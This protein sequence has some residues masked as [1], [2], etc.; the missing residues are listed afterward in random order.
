[1]NELDRVRQLLPWYA[2]GVLVDEECA[3][4]DQWLKANVTKYP[5]IA[6]ELAWLR[7]TAVQL[8]ALARAARQPVD[9]GL[10]TLMQR[11]AFERPREPGNLLDDAI[12]DPAQPAVIQ[13]SKLTGTPHRNSQ[14]GDQPATGM[15]IMAWF[16]G[17]TG[18]GSPALAMGLVA[19]VIAQTGVIG[20]LL[21]HAP[22]NQVSL[23]GATDTVAASIDQVFLKVAFNPG[24]TESAL[25]HVLGS[26]NAQIVAGPS[27]LGLYTVAVS[28]AQVDSAIAQLRRNA[29]VVESVQR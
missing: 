21:M 12:Q 8:Q 2:Q 1:M 27:A 20:A 28:G 22:A 9:E 14:I 4:M 16:S 15:R 13:S 10:N 23:G 17:L 29:S 6:A 5:D 11:I 7:S 19:V 3:F 18:I 26:A 25:R 24:T